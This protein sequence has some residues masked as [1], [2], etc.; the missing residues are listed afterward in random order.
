MKKAVTLT[1]S[2]PVAKEVMYRQ[3][4]FLVADEELP[5]SRWSISTSQFSLI[6]LHSA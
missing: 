6:P 3:V 5:E 1:K 4:Y 2:A